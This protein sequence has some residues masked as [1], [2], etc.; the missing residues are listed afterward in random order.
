M[1]EVTLAT[2][3]VP[4]T[5]AT[6]ETTIYVDSVTKKLK[7]KDDTGA[8]TDY[9]NPGGSVTSLTGDVTGTGPGATPTTIADAIVTGKLLTGLVLASG[10]P[11]ATD[12]ILQAFGKLLGKLN[13]AQIF[14]TGADGDVT[15]TND[16]TLVRDMYYNN[17]TINTG[18]NL[19]TAGYRIFVLNTL[20]VNTGATIDRSGVSAIATAGALALVAGTLGASGAGG[21]GGTA[22]GTAGSATTTST[23]GNGGAGGS[24]SGGAGGAAGTVTAPTALVGGV[25]QLNQTRQA[26]VLRDLGNTIMTGGAGGG[27]GGGSGVNT[28]GGGG[29]GGGL[30]MIAAR[31]MTG[32]GSIKAMGGNGF[33]APGA[34]AGGGGGGGGGTIVTITENDTTATSLSFSAA[35]G[36]GG[37]GQG[38]GTGGANGSVG[39][40]FRLRS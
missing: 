11:V 21:A 23:G 19:F 1:A 34:N 32:T 3:T 28:A 6:G 30:I 17:L 40:I 12:T 37:G 25:E 14:G 39:R 36:V 33:A 9:A 38:T 29:S 10:T 31:T 8:V 2:Q 26:L 18:I 27:G 15:L 13:N 20:T 22:A 4:V 24:G 16:T 5:P 35:A 7:S